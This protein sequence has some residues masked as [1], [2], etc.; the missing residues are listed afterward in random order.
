MATTYQDIGYGRTKELAMAD[1]YSKVEKRLGV[2]K[3]MVFIVA[4]RD[5]LPSDTFDRSFGYRCVYSLANTGGATPS[6][7]ETRTRRVATLSEPPNVGESLVGRVE[8]LSN[9]FTGK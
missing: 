4:D 2:G 3:D 1:F 7:G 6:N 5:V 8:R 9:P